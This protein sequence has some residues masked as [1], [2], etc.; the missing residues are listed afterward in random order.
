MTVNEFFDLFLE[1]LL[2]HPKL[3]Y[4]YKFHQNPSR[5]LFRKAYFCQ[6]L[7]YI[8]D[9]VQHNPGKVWDVGCG[10]GTTGIF[11]ALNGIPVFGT[12][13]EH[14]LKEIPSRLEFYK[15][16]GN[17]DLFTYSYEDLFS[18]GYRNEFNTVIIQDTLHHLEPIA[19]AL[20]V[21]NSS[22][23]DGGRMIV[24]E[25]NGSNII[26]SAKLYKQRGNKRIIEIYD[27][28][29]GR[30]ILLGNENIRS[31]EEWTRLMEQHGFRVDEQ[32]VN[33]VRYY[34]LKKF[35]SSNYEQLI[36]KEQALWKKS[37]FRKKYFFFGLNFV[38]VKI[39]GFENRS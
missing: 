2:N 1:E 37:P 25:E 11:L 7:Q 28:A 33:Y 18:S 36:Q 19:D 9:Q 35:T 5:L 13:L 22:L 32:S 30:K 27:E 34:L 31:L 24:V 14:Y 3:H 4:Y 6:R 17:T 21:L 12:T 8:Y 15:P 38:A 10:F 29:L 20:E 23:T 16:Y 26:Q 39:S